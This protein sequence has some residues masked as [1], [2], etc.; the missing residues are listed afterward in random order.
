MIGLPA[1]RIGS[2]FLAVTT[3]AFAVALDSYVLNVNNFPELVPSNV[4]PAAAVRALR[5]RGPVRDVRPVPRGARPCGSRWRSACARPR[6]GRTLMATRDNE[7]AAAAAGVRA[8]PREARRLPAGRHDR[9]GGRRRSTCSCCTASRPGSYP[10][11]DSITC[12]PPRSS[13]GSARSSAPS[14]ACCCSGTSRPCRPSATSASSSPAPACCS[15]STPLPG[16][17][18]QV[19]RRAARPPARGRGPPPRH[20]PRRARPPTAPTRRTPSA[21][22]AALDRRSRRGRAPCAERAGASAACGADR[23]RCRAGASTSAYGT[24]QVVRGFDL[25]VARGEMVAL[26]GTNGAGKSTVLKGISGLLPADRRRGHPRGRGH[27]RPGRP[28]QLAHRGLALVPGGPGVFPSL[29]VAENLRHGRLDA[30]PRQGPTRRRP[31]SRG[32]RAVPG[33]ARPASTCRPARCPAASSRCSA[34]PA[35]S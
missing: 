17:L 11:G 14:S 31:P 29:T 22:D 20:R 18:G 6:T 35:R 7:R 21:A 2:L 32:A 12:S 30:A 15:C 3:I 4:P 24:L 28:T 13:A 25:D 26:L 8:D 5:P 1:L 16:G 23:R 27:H 10:V 9:R 19:L 34:W 33:A